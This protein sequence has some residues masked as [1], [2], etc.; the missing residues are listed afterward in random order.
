MKAKKA[1]ALT[2]AERWPELWQECAPKRKKAK[3]K[4]DDLIPLTFKWE[5]T[6]GVPKPKTKAKR[7]T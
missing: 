1:K 6:Y 7:R 2:A 5:I 4:D 3:A